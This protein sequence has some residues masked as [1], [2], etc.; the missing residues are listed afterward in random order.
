MKMKCVVIDDEPL[1]LELI[2][3]YS[4]DFPELDVVT[5]FDDPL[6]GA[7]YLRGNKVD[8]LFIDINMPH[9]TGLELVGALQ[10]KPLVI[11]TTAHKNFALE[12]FEL[13]ALDYLLKPI[14][15][16]RFERAIK[17]AVAQYTFINR[18]TEDTAPSL[19]VRSE[20]KLIKI[21]V[22]DIVY[23]E[24][25]ED[26]IKIHLQA[27]PHPI[28][29]LMS[30]KEVFTKLPP[31]EFSRIHRSYIVANSQVRSVLNKKVYL[32]THKELPVSDSYQD[33]ISRWKDK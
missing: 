22:R 16:E 31:D 30:L 1:A 28:L 17:R 24:G 33:F 32:T 29:T 27:S 14:S 13:E 15:P 6:E 11:F 9:L 7:A 19:F 18:G 26:Y 2:R 12:G 8:L 4:K 23:I 10:E 21:N 20:Y 5:T 25:M 3:K